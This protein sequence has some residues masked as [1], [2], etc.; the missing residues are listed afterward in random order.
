MG[1]LV[2]SGP[3]GQI[4][5]CRRAARGDSA[6]CLG[7]DSLLRRH[8]GLLPRPRQ[9]ARLRPPPLGPRRGP[10]PGTASTRG[11]AVAWQ[12]RSV[13]GRHH[14]NLAR[15]ARKP[16]GLSATEQSETGPRFPDAAPGGVVIVGD[17]R[18]AGHGQGTLSRQADRRDRLVAATAG[19]GPS[20]RHSAG[21]SLLLHVLAGGVGPSRRR[22]G[23]VSPASPARL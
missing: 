6:H 20:R 10:Q 17:R 12:A 7:T 2:A 22:G 13:G 9:V 4:V 3:R 19:G 8:G 5:P 1:I 14:H 11:L 15:Y 18:P 16:T 21:R 23:G